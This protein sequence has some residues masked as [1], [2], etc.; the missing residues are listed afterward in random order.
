MHRILPIHKLYTYDLLKFALRSY[1]NFV[2]NEYLNLICHCQYSRNLRSSSV[3]IISTPNVK[4]QLS[5]LF[6]AYACQT[7]E[8][9]SSIV[10]IWFEFFMWQSNTT[11]CS[12]LQ[13]Q[14][15]IIRQWNYWYCFCIVLFFIIRSLHILPRG[16][17]SRLVSQCLLFRSIPI[18]FHFCLSFIL[19]LSHT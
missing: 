3:H 7:S 16:K 14:C 17:P 5:K 10:L 9:H 18:F 15:P 1:N 19:C 11:F 4:G 6:I 13:G 2:D 8:L 12:L